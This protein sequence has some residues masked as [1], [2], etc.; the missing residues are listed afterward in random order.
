MDIIFS[1][2][3]SYEELAE[4]IRYELMMIHHYTIRKCIVNLQKIAIYPKGGVD[5]V[6]NVW[7]P[8]VVKAGI[9][10][11]AFIVPENMFAQLDMQAAHTE[12][13]E[14]K[15]MHTKYFIEASTA[16]EWIRKF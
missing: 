15:V 6:R 7:F 13:E 5:H 16:L 12:A 9:T 11:V 3:V 10:H 1:G 4:A 2:F 8:E 14:K